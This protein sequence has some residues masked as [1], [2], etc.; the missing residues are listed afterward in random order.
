MCAASALNKFYFKDGSAPPRQFQEFTVNKRKLYLYV[1]SVLACYL[2]A[3]IIFSDL[4]L[5]YNLVVV[6]FSYPQ[7]LRA[8]TAPRGNEL[9]CIDSHKQPSRFPLSLSMFIALARDYTARV[10]EEIR[11]RKYAFVRFRNIS[12]ILSENGHYGQPI[13]ISR[14]AKWA[15]FCQHGRM[16]GPKR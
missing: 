16:D 9:R 8:G 11:K 3:T 7:P 5:G 14:L 4:D 1:N 10:F 2:P 15:L 6:T 13:Y 12:S